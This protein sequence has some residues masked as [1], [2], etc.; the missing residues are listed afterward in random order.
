M[1]DMKTLWVA[2]TMA[3]SLAT[4]A[5]ATTVD[6]IVTAFSAS[7]LRGNPV[8][9]AYAPFP[10][11]TPAPA[12]LGEFTLNV[13]AADGYLFEALGRTG[14]PTSLDIS[15]TWTFDETLSGSARRRAS[16]PSRSTTSPS[17]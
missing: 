6:V 3:A 16:D 12:G 5:S 17:R 7:G 4:G 9:Q 15:A 2:A 10:A 8:E 13:L 14:F 1:E 11:I